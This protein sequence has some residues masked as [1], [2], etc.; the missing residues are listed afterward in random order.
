MKNLSSF[1]ARLKK[2]FAS[3]SPQLK[4]AARWVIDH[5]ADVALLSLR[6]QARRAGIPPATLTRLGQRLGLQGYDGVRKLHAE[7]VRQRPENYRGRAEELLERRKTEGDSALVQD[8]FA[9]LAQHLQN[10]SLPAAIERFTAA[11]DLIAGAKRV[12]CLG[13]RSSFAV[14]YIFHYVRSLFASNSVLVDG[15]GGSGIDVLR[16]IGE[17]DVLLVISV[18]RYVRHTVEA[19]KFAKDRGARI[20]ALTDSE[21][22]P[23]IAVAD[24][25]ILVR[26][27]TPS[28]FHTMAPAFAAV[29][30]LAALIAARRGRETLVA[31]DESERQLAAFGTYLLPRAKGPRPS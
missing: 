20:V 9:S 2:G 4:V 7:A 15:S 19:A 27:E 5:P 11:A 24:E 23:L 31:L 29:E 30:C 14:A 12:F 28:F 18:N 17:G 26:T 3:L 13:Q 8:I 16:G 22:S 1:N 10:L 25:T 21:L 6:E